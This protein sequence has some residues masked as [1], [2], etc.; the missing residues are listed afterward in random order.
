M[1]VVSFVGG[2][3]GR[4]RYNV[5]LGPGHLSDGSVIIG[6]LL[7]ACYLRPP[8]MTPSSFWRSA[9]TWSVSSTSSR[10]TSLCCAK[11]R[12]VTS[13]ALTKPSPFFPLYG[14]VQRAGRGRENI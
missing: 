13:L 2:E 9:G 6:Y 14:A 5:G 7:L 11:K 1:A 4:R 8:N 10:P 3:K 12:E